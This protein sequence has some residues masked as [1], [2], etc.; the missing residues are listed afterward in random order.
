MLLL[1]HMLIH[2]LHFSQ[3]YQQW[4]H[5]SEVC[6]ET[7]LVNIPSSSC[8]EMCGLK[9][10]STLLIIY[11]SKSTKL[12]ILLSLYNISSHIRRKSIVFSPSDFFSLSTNLLQP[13]WWSAVAYSKVSSVLLR[14]L[15]LMSSRFIDSLLTFYPL[16]S[17]LCSPPCVYQL[18]QPLF[19]SY[20]YFLVE[21]CGSWCTSVIAR[22]S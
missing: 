6:C 13:T 17:G 8:L 21:V 3:C 12:S 20:S 19:S 15:F 18:R 4:V 22:P 9:N 2:I 11:T 7:T 10:F 16:F 14:M 5:T 1:K